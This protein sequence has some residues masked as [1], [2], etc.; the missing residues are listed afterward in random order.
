MAQM[1]RDRKQEEMKEVAGGEKGIEQYR[2]EKLQTIGTAQ[3][4]ELKIFLSIDKK[5]GYQVRYYTDTTPSNGELPRVSVEDVCRWLPYKGSRVVKSNMIQQSPG[6][7]VQKGNPLRVYH[8]SDIEK[9]FRQCEVWKARVDAEWARKNREAEYLRLQLQAR[10]RPVAPSGLWE[11]LA[12]QRQHPAPEPRWWEKAIGNIGAGILLGA[13]FGPGAGLAGR[14]A[15]VCCRPIS[16]ATVP[17]VIPVTP[18]V[19]CVPIYP[20]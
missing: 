5:P 10:Q 16:P 13:I 9:V 15:A 1:E 3:P 2:I 17:P 6:T 14:A 12:Y 18:E 19:C 20:P 8:F 4:E 11:T 7:Y